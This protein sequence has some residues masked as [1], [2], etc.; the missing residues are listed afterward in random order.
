MDERDFKTMK[1]DIIEK[2]GDTFASIDKEFEYSWRVI[3][4]KGYDF[5]RI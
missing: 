2:M 1:L 3:C 4:D 5:D